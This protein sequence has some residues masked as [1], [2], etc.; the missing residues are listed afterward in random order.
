MSERTHN[1][2]PLMTLAEAAD[3]VGSSASFLRRQIA[4][5]RLEGTFLGRLVRVRRSS[6]ERFI[7][8]QTSNEGRA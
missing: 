5:G 1:P 8:A 6:L 4:A 3:Y 7:A 2:D